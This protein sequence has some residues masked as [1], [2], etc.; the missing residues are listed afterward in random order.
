[1]S[2]WLVRFRDAG[3][4]AIAA[5]SPARA[6]SLAAEELVRAA[7]LE[8]RLAPEHFATRFALSTKRDRVKML[9][10][11]SEGLIGP[12]S[13]RKTRQAERRLRE[14]VACQARIE[15]HVRRVV[16]SAPPMPPE[17]VQA[18]LEVFYRAARNRQMRID[19]GVEDVDPP[20]WDD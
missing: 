2:L 9:D 17:A 3:V 13:R 12:D 1:M 16:D 19:L 8:V 20:Y 4:L 5:D 11:L 10:A 18:A 15:A 7:R 14:H 6:L